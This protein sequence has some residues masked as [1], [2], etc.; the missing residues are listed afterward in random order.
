ML[1]TMTPQELKKAALIYKGNKCI[2]CGYIRCNAALE[3]HH[4]NP[5][6]KK[7]NISDIKNWDDMQKELDKCVLVCSNCHMEIHSGFV[8]LT[9]FDDLLN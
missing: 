4:I 3:F 5:F 9:I 1:L 2:L 7:A 6:Q 8:D